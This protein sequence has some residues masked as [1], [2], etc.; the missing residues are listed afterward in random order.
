MEM[1]GSKLTPEYTFLMMVVTKENTDMKEIQ[2]KILRWYSV[3]EVRHKLLSTMLES[4][5]TF[6]IWQLVVG[7]TTTH[8]KALLIIQSCQHDFMGSVINHAADQCY[9]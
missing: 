2:R 7:S 6:Y 8:E 5:M 9:S 3:L 4:I 1:W